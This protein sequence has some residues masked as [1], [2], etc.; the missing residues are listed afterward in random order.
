MSKALP[1]DVKYIFVKP[2]VVMTNLKTGKTFFEMKRKTPTRPDGTEECYYLF[3]FYD[4]NMPNDEAKAGIHEMFRE[5]MC[6]TAA[7][8]D[9]GM[10]SFDEM[11]EQLR[12]KVKKIHESGKE[13]TEDQ[14]DVKID[15]YDHAANRMDKLTIGISTKPAGGKDNGTA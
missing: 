12:K 6:P 9:I 15:I 3:K 2:N 4:E 8:L 5:A 7:M 11:T 14:I 13:L 10:F 1:N